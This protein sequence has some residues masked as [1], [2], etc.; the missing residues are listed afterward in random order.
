MFSTQ[1]GSRRSHETAFIAWPFIAQ[2]RV[3]RISVP[4]LVMSSEHDWMT[5]SG[6]GRRIAEAIPNS[7]LVL[8]ENSGHKPFASQEKRAC[9]DV[10]SKFI[11]S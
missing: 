1:N 7:Q 6:Q 2:P 5:R 4:T 3:Y 10:A 11:E 9:L 8:F